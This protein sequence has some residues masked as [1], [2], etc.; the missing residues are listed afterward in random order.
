MTWKGLS[1]LNVRQGHLTGREEALL[2]TGLCPKGVGAAPNITWP[3]PLHLCKGR[4]EKL[5]KS[6]PF[7]PLESISVSSKVS[8]AQACCAFKD[9][10]MTLHGFFLP[11]ISFPPF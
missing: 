3:Q 8:T 4:W 5:G 9:I 1:G 7:G 6:P 11:F 2:L 10:S